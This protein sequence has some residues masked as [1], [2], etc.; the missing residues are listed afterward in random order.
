MDT[1]PEESSVSQIMVPS[2]LVARALVPLQDNRLPKE[3]LVLVLKELVLMPPLKVEVE[4]VPLT[5]RKPVITVEVP[6][7][8]T[9]NL[10]NLMP[11]SQAGTEPE[12]VRMVEEA[13][14]ANSEKEPAEPP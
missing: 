13:P 3:M 7:P 6:P 8:V 1:A 9:S 12:V 4:T 14:A 5:S 10:S 2:A 11:V